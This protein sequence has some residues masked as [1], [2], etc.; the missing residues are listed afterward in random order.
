MQ[1]KALTKH[2]DM[3]KNYTISFRVKFTLEKYC[4]NYIECR[5]YTEKKIVDIFVHPLYV[6]TNM[7]SA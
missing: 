3:N 7:A 4:I 2:F 5:L 1:K 6:V